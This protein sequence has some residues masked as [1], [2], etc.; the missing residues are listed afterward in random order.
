MLALFEGEF[1]RWEDR[2]A[3]AQWLFDARTAPVESLE[4]LAG[5]L[6]M[7]FDGSVDE[8][9]R[10]LMIRYAMNVYA[11]R[12]T[13]SGVL[14]AATLAWEECIDESWLVSPEQL[15]ER[16]HGLRLQELFG[17][18]QPLSK[19]AWTPA[20]GRTTLLTAL[21]GDPGLFDP[22][23]LA[24]V[25]T[26]AAPVAGGTAT[27]G[28]KLRAALG[29]LPRSAQEEAKLWQAWSNE[30]DNLPTD[31]PETAESRRDWTDYLQSSQPCAPLRQRWQEFLARR[32][33]RVSALNAEW[34]AHW[35]GFERIPCPVQ[36]P[37]TDKTLADWHRFEAQ[38]L[39]GLA[40]AHRFRVLLP[41]TAGVLDIHELAR[42]RLSVLRVVEREKPAHT[43]AEVRFGFDLFRVGEARLGLDTRLEVGL[44]RRP[45]LAALGYS[46][47]AATPALLGRT[48]IGGA[49]PVPPRPQPPA[50]RVGL[51]RG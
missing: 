36:V 40:N 6:G 45:E 27:R 15:A 23:E 3:Q 26:V 43:V 38:V 50:D 19:T 41:L 8:A 37:A 22:A 21:D 1:T 51:D 31:E 48:E 13:V 46:V 34:G 24:I 30:I 18:A 32:W 12:G 17:V 49:I 5:W 14:L 47:N 44:A 2:I 10:R 35:R 28:V 25:Q 42:R 29:F 7:A 33:R 4:W 16:P 9:R 20:Q 11:R 39:R